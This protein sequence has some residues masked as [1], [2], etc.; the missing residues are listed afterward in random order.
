MLGT[1]VIGAALCMHGTGSYL[2]GFP[3]FGEGASGF[4]NLGADWG[5]IGYLA[6]WIVLSIIGTY[7]QQKYPGE[8]KDDV[9]TQ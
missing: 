3:S 6:G 1:A 9:W 8:T 7:V 5:Y 4:K 2:G